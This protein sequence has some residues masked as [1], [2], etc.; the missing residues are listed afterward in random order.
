MNTAL[1]N[2]HDEIPQWHITG[3]WFDVCSCNVP[4]PC[5]LA[6]P[7]TNNACDA[8]FAYRIREGHFGKVEIAG[9]N[10]VIIGGFTGSIW[11]GDK[12]DACVF[13]DATA[14][15]EQRYAL[16]QIFTGQ[17]GG[18]QAK[19]VP[20]I[21]GALRGVEFADI[22]I[23]IDKSLEHWS[24]VIPNIVSAKGEALTGPTADPNKRVQTFNATGSEVG[25]D[26]G[27]I[28]WGKC[29]EGRWHAFGF[30]QDIPA[31]QNSKHIP[32]TWKGPDAEIPFP[33][34]GPRAL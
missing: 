1:H 14:T 15:D 6:Q 18:W 24:V 29:V 27:P 8:I 22:T 10:V 20:P 17:A 3:D 26:S 25:P 21:L 31:G 19:Y 12:L 16:Q 2:E 4:C 11:H 9:L 28:T 13:F 34:S 32:F 5:S 7:P 30:S 33:W 23:E